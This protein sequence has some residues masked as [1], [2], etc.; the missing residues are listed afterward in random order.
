[1]LNKTMI[2]MTG[3]CLCAGGLFA[4]DDEI[5]VAIAKIGPTPA[6]EADAEKKGV[7]GNLNVFI[8]GLEAV[9][10][11]AMTEKSPFTIMG[12]REGWAAYNS[13]FH[14]QQFDAEDNL[15]EKVKYGLSLRVSGYDEEV[16]TKPAPGGRVQAGLRLKASV[17]MTL[18]EAG[19]MKQRVATT[20]NREKV[21]ERYL[22]GGGGAAPAGAAKGGANYTVLVLDNSG[23][24]AGVPLEKTKQAAAKFCDMLGQAK[25]QQQ[26]ALVVYSSSANLLQGFT[27]DVGLV[28][29]KISEIG[30]GGSTNTGEALEIAGR[31]LDAVAD[32]GASKNIVLMTDGLPN[33]GPSTKDVAAAL[34]P[35]CSIYT[36]GFYHQLRSNSGELASAQELLKGIQ[37]AGYYEVDDPN[38]LEFKFKV[39][40]N[41]VTAPVRATESDEDIYNAVGSLLQDFIKETAENLAEELVKNYYKGPALVIR[42]DDGEV[43]IDRGEGWCKKGDVLTIRGPAEVKESR[44]TKITIPGKKLGEMKVTEVFPGY[45]MGTTT[46]KDVPEDS[47]VDKN[48]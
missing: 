4:Q 20:V 35:K 46:A 1:M 45:A 17:T 12:G 36:L 11:S 42:F 44:G 27:T 40:A 30:N 13:L 9:V 6:A 41:A 7:L 18:L 38:D 23:S 21:T 3:V 15:P 25:G 26:I 48:Q 22:N 37:N 33:V 16:R 5:V 8:E 29:Q 39:I 31:E 2:W 34:K 47:V 32:A 14:E 24:M 43:T 19:T 28:K 10:G